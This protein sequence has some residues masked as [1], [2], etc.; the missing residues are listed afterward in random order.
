MWVTGVY[1]FDGQ[2]QKKP[3]SEITFRIIVLAPILLSVFNCKSNVRLCL[4]VNEEFKMIYLPLVVL[5]PVRILHLGGV[6]GTLLICILFNC[7]FLVSLHFLLSFHH[8][9]CTYFSNLRFANWR[10]DEFCKCDCI[11]LQKMY[12]LFEKIY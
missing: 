12:L 2:A 9:T 8:I 3:N 11:L 1:M 5:L 4:I 10:I 7:Y 6:S